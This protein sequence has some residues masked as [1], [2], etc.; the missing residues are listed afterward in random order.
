LE[1][2]QLQTDTLE[3]DYFFKEIHQ[4]WLADSTPSL[5]VFCER[6]G[7]SQADSVSIV[8]ILRET[9]KSNADNLTDYLRDAMAQCARQIVVN[10]IFI[11][12]FQKYQGL[13]KSAVRSGIG[14]AKDS[15]SLEDL[16]GD[17]WLLILRHLSTYTYQSDG[18]ERAWLRQLASG[19]GRHAREK[20]QGRVRTVGKALERD[21][22]AVME[23]AGQS[24]ALT[25]EDK[26]EIGEEVGEE[27]G[28]YGCN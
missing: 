15:C 25:Y 7:S 18:Q 23:A 27:R 19:V 2:D 22:G 5:Q 10:T 26:V 20:V 1:H 3:L 12:F 8:Q 9:F 24:Y 11:Q 14:T 6:A 21:K 13:V 17:A 16:T 28:D 4:Q